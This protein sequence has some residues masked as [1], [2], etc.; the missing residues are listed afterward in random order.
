MNNLNFVVFLNFKRTC[1]TVDLEGL[2][3][4]TKN[5]TIK[6]IPPIRLQNSLVNKK[7]N[8]C[9]HGIRSLGVSLNTGVL[10]G[11]GLG[12][13]LFIL[14]VDDIEKTLEHNKLHLFA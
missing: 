14:H 5:Y 4:R 7:Q 11:S 6:A 9:C 1:G 10:Q 13:L 3:I 8:V 2:M 12:P